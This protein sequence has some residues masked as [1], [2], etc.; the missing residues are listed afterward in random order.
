MLLACLSTKR[1]FSLFSS[2]Q[3]MIIHCHKL[4]YFHL[5]F[6]VITKGRA[7]VTMCMYILEERKSSQPEKTHSASQAHKRSNRFLI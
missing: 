5:L 2:K 6:L 1:S 4:T 7:E 3:H